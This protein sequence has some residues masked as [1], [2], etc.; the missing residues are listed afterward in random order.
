MAIKQKLVKSLHA[1]T[2]CYGPLSRFKYFFSAEYEMQMRLGASAPFHLC[3]RELPLFQ[4]VR[5][6]VPRSTLHS[7]NHSRQVNY[8]LTVIVP[9][10]LQFLVDRVATSHFEHWYYLA[11]VV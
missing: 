7:M 8:R 5:H 2:Y 6:R 10:S 1:K 11:I 4:R 3:E 9:G